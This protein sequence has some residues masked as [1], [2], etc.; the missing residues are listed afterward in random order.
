MP[1]LY[2]PMF[3]WTNLELINWTKKTQ[4]FTLVQTTPPFVLLIS[5]RAPVSSCA[6]KEKLQL[7]L[8]VSAG[9]L[10][11]EEHVLNSASPLDANFHK[12]YFFQ[13]NVR[14]PNGSRSNNHHQPQQQQQLLH[15][16]PWKQILCQVSP[17]RQLRQT[18]YCV[19]FR[20]EHFSNDVRSD[21][22]RK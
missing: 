14:T 8:S 5:Q 10:F 4:L 20:W 18:C 3:D 12:K 19:S 22:G 1:L 21:V 2:L 9:I 17:A 7:R 13:E 6:I 15:A 16:Q 11:V